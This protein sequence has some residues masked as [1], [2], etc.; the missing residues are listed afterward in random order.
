MLLVT[1]DKSWK[2]LLFQMHAFSLRVYNPPYYCSNQGTWGYADLHGT[3]LALLRHQVVLGQSINQN[4]ISREETWHCTSAHMWCLYANV[5]EISATNDYMPAVT[6]SCH[7]FS[8]DE[9]GVP[10]MWH[11]ISVRKSGFILT[12]NEILA[13]LLLIKN[14]QEICCCV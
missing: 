3:L 4:V 11:V 9:G 2:E 10:H 8:Q 5:S 7:F 13:D 6:Q 12:D 14:L 1:N